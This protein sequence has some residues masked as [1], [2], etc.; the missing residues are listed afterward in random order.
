[1]PQLNPA[2]WFLTLLSTWLIFTLVMQPK[3]LPF[4]P[5]NSPSSKTTT[6]T[7]IFPWNWPWT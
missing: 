6:T 7:H 1:M 5:T 4:I 3:I 2:P